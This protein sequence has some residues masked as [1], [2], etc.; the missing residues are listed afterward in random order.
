VL[1]QR[2]N[3]LEQQGVIRYFLLS[4]QMVAVVAVAIVIETENQEVQ[5]AAHQEMELLVLAIPHRLLR[6]KVTTAVLVSIRQILMGA[7][8]VALAQ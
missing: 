8:V 6:A 7:A 1:P 3:F 5:A 4:L 2:Q